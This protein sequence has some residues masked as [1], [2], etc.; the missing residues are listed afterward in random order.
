VRAGDLYTVLRYTNADGVYEMTEASGSWKRITPK[1]GSIVTHPRVARVVFLVGTDDWDPPLDRIDASSGEVVSIA[2]PS[3]G[4]RPRYVEFV[5]R[6]AFGVGAWATESLFF[7]RHGELLRTND[8]GRNW[9]SSLTAVRAFATT[10]L[11]NT[12]YA[13]SRFGYLYRSD[14]AGKNW[15]TTISTFAMDDLGVVSVDPHDPNLLLATAGNGLWRS[16]DG[17]HTWDRTLLYSGNSLY[18]RWRIEFDPSSDRIF[19][20]FG[21]GG[22]KLMRSDDRG[23][24]RRRSHVK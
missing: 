5:G 9:T 18:A 8:G 20:L 6:N 1:T 19:A 21:Y 16:E 17:G 3:A 7:L 13:L 11:E 4:P 12:I 14:D 23:R 15:S 24:A 10:S 2:P 22:L